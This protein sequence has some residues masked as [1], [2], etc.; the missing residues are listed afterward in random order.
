MIHEVPFILNGRQVT[1]VAS[2]SD[3]LLDVLRRP[4]GMTG[5]K[6]GCGQGECGACT[7]IVDG[8]PINACLFPALEA[9]GKRVTTIEGLVGPGNKLSEVQQAFVDAGGIQ[10]GFCSPGMILSAAALLEQNRE[11]SDDDIAEALAGNL[12]R[13]TGYVQ[14]VDSVRRAAAAMRNR[15]DTGERDE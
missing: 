14:I 7:V 1:V 12:C 2:P 11:P 10:C 13:C 5:V 8:R 4:L 9:E 15:D 3:L 6:E